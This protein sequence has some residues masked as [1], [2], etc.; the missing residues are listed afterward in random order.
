MASSA[1]Q[2]DGSFLERIGI[3]PALAMGFVGLLLF[4]VG[5]GVVDGSGWQLT[6]SGVNGLTLVYV[7]CAAVGGWLAAAL[8]DAWGPRRVMTL[9]MA[10]W[11]AVEL[12]WLVAA[13]AGS[14]GF[15]VALL[16]YGLRAAAFSIFSLAFLVWVVAVA[17]KWRLA[18]S[19][20]WFFFLIL[21]GS[22]VLGPLLLPKLQNMSGMG[23]GVVAILAGVLGGALA[24]V[25][26]RE[27]RG[28]SPL[29][30]NPTTTGE[31]LSR[32][33]SVAWRKPLI[34]VASL[35]RAFQVAPAIAFLWLFPQQWALVLLSWIVL[36]TA[37]GS[38]IFGLVAD[39]FGWR[40]TISYFG[41]I[42]SALLLAAIYYTPTMTHDG[43]VMAA[44]GAAYGLFLGANFPL[45][46]LT[47]MMSPNHK[48]EAVS[49]L[50][51][52]VVLG[53]LLSVVLVKVLGPHVHGA[54]MV[55]TFAGLHLVGGLI[56]LAIRN[57]TDTMAAM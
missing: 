21:L 30:Y 46:A 56:A 6:V 3:P 29:V 39:S 22:K 44:V 14:T 45:Y 15:A 32:S 11:V 49:L 53:T 17:R 28:S 19:V 37:V 57:N 51:W 16:L 24:L 1:V 34:F 8:S 12:V 7:L 41:G 9:G 23:S 55:L 43:T 25:G 26:I 54:G 42:V 33:I 5:Q 47:A 36:G 18:S 10:L 38:L 13:P 35:V 40:K 52:G 2:D 20:G 27:R 4:A 50:G 31:A 48:G